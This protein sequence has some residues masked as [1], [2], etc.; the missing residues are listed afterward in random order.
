[1]PEWTRE[2]KK[3]IDSRDGS[4]LVSAAAGSVLYRIIIQAAYQINMPSYTVKLLSV[5]IVA[6]ALSLPL[7]KRRFA[8]ERARRG[9][10]EGNG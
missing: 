10:E 6:A 1:M 5:L 8:L 3:A 9:K 2:Q 4:I 7:L